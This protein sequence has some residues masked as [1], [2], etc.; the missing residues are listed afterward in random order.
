MSK[1]VLITG[2]AKRI[3]RAIALHM[4][5]QGWD[6]AV[7]YHRSEGEAED[8]VEQVKSLGRR[9]TMIKADLSDENQVKSIVPHVLDELGNINCLINNA[10]IFENDTVLDSVHEKWQVHQDTNLRAPMLLAQE[11]VKQLPEEWQGHIINLLD[12]CVWRLPENFTSYTVSKSGLWTLTKIMALQFAPQVRVNG[13]GPGNTLMNPKEPKAHFENARARTPLQ[14]GG[15][16]EEICL[17]V[18]FFLNAP[19]VT[20]QMVVLDGGKHLMTPGVY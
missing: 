4:A 9:A 15:S 19:S 2:A 20:G 17:T 10:S 12:Y 7:H 5:R 16:P 8:C 1:V 11:F 13:I 6:V 3:G 14:N 18:D